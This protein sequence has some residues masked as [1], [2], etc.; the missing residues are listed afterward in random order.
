LTREYKYLFGPVPSRRL[1]L[2][3]GVDIV[4]FK[5]CTQNCIYCQLGTDGVL[6]LERRA[7]VPI[8]DVLAE[9][10]QRIAEGLTADYVTISGSGEP[11]LHSGLGELIDGIHALTAIPVAVIT[12]GTLLSDP[13]VRADCARADAVLPSLDAGDET[14]YRRINCPHGG[15]DFMTFVEGLRRF[16]K[17]YRGR[18]WLEVFF[19]EGLNTGEDQVAAIA[20]LIKH[21][22]PDKVHLNTA[23]RPPASAQAVVVSPERLAEIARKLGPRAE[24]IAD[25]PTRPATPR[26]A[27][28]AATIVQTLRRRPCRVE[29]LCRALG[30]NPGETV[31]TLAALE[32]A[33]QVVQA[34]RQGQVFYTVPA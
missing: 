28:L 22:S 31:K 8:A 34:L 2:S 30:A 20:R 12:N 24:V 29:D 5:T 14:V 11:T 3:L 18:Y 7:Y 19:V 33:G 1:G 26:D 6:T 13:Q 16:R 32:R 17:E 4:P 10:R 9:L 15:I 21:I 25:Y 27:D 23:V